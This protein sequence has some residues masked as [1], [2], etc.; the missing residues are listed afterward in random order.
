MDLHNKFAVLTVNITSIGAPRKQYYKLTTGKAVYD[1]IALD[2]LVKSC[3][4]KYDIITGYV[5]DTAIVPDVKSYIDEQYRLKSSAEGFDRDFYKLCL[6]APLGKCLRKA[7]KTSKT[8]EFA[9]KD[10]ALKYV[11]RNSHMLNHIEESD[12]KYKVIMNY[13]IDKAFND[14]H[15]GLAILSAAR[16]IMDELF[17]TCEEKGIAVYYS[18]TD[19]IAIDTSNVPLLQHMI[20]SEL[21]QL[22]IEAQGEAEIIDTRHYRVGSHIRPRTK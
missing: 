17:Q 11:A 12:G 9:T 4:I 14:S 6:N 10:A 20:G 2:T 21:G 15:V 16:A 19:C 1:T 18:H 22:K 8:K 5:W 13:C 7:Y 3:N